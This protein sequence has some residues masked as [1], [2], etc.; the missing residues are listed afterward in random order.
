[1]MNVGVSLRHENVTVI[2]NDPN[3]PVIKEADPLGMLVFATVG[4]IAY[5]LGVLLGRYCKAKTCG[6]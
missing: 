5:Y 1:M 6:K 2:T 4:K 3:V